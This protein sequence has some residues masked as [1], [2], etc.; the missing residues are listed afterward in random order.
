MRRRINVTDEDI[1]NGVPGQ[2]WFCPIALAIRRELGLVAGEVAA[3]GSCC[4]VL[5]D[6]TIQLPS[7]AGDF[8]NCFDEGLPVG[9]FAFDLVLPD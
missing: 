4:R 7:E 3:Y 5:K 2:S 8:I 1:S 6:D 9:P